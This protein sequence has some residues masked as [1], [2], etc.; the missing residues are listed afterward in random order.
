MASA[1]AAAAVV[2]SI[3]NAASLTLG[4]AWARSASMAA[5]LIGGCCCRVMLGRLS[6][7]TLGE[8][9][10]ASG[11][12]REAIQEIRT[13]LTS[14]PEAARGRS[15]WKYVDDSDDDKDEKDDQVKRAR[16]PNIGRCGSAGA[17][18]PSDS[19][20]AP[21]VQATARGSSSDTR[22]QCDA[23]QRVQVTASDEMAAA[24]LRADQHEQVSESGEQRSTRL[25]A[26]ARGYVGS[27]SRKNGFRRLHLL[28]RCY[29]VTGIDYSQFECFASSARIFPH[30]SRRTR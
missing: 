15:I 20:E 26:D 2:S 5:R 28:G 13:S 11:Y 17:S 1:E 4:A 24:H 12:D 14:F 8:R 16:G 10:S 9:L 27:I 3:S 29:R 6:L 30:G 23:A 18:P 25:L 21:L 19:D 22:A 7:G